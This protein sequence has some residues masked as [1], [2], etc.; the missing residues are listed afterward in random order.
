[1]KDMLVYCFKE[2]QKGGEHNADSKSN[3]RMNEPSATNSIAFTQ[4]NGIYAYAFIL[5]I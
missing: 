4:Q 2:V 5:S 1:M 3:G